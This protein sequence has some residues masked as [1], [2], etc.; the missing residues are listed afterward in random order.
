MA[1]CIAGTVAL[2][3]VVA[4]PGV[5]RSVFGGPLLVWRIAV[6]D[7]GLGEGALFEML[8]AAEHHLSD[9]S[10]WIVGPVVVAMGMA[11]PFH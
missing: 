8:P 1:H 7:A 10:V 4:A 11:V 5:M 2:G 6:L 9:W 3:L